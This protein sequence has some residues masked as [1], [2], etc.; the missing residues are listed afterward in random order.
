MSDEEVDARPGWWKS[1]ELRRFCG[2]TTLSSRAVV[3]P[4]SKESAE[5]TLYV[6]SCVQVKYQQWGKPRRH[7]H[8]RYLTV[9]NDCG[10]CG[11]QVQ[12]RGSLC[13]GTFR[14]HNQPSHAA[15]RIVNLINFLDTDFVTSQGEGDN[16]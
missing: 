15:K 2:E 12:E 3:I 16:C 6:Q 11:T 13:R 7:G 9:P 5:A 4:S 14:R 10:S 1:V 8:Y